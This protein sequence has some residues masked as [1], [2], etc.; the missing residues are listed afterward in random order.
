MLN[1]ARVRYH[2]LRP[3][4]AATLRLGIPIAIGQLGVIVMG[5]ADTMMVGHYSTDALAAASFVNNMFTFVSFLLM[6]YSYGLTPLISALVG[7]GKK[8]EAGTVLKNALAANV[9]YCALV[10]GIMTLLYFFLDRL[11]QP[12][13]LLPLIRPYYLIV[14]I[15]MAFVMLLNVFRQFTD[16][17]TDTATGMWALLSGNVLN[18]VGN[19]LLIYGIG[20]FPE[21]GLNGAGLSTLFARLVIVLI[22]LCVLL[23][24]RRYRE[25]R[26]GFFAGKTLSREVI[27]I[28]K[29]SLPVSLQMGMESGAFTFSAVMAGWMGAIELAAYQVLV[30][31]G[32]LGFLFYY[33]FGAG[34]SIRV[35]SF[36]GQ[37]D[38]ERVH[39][40]ALAGRDILLVIATFSSLVFFLFAAPM[41]KIFTTDAEVIAMGVTLIPALI[42]YQYGDAMQICYANVLRGTSHVLSMMWIAFVSYILINIPAAYLLAFTFGLGLH[43]IFIAFSIGLFTASALFYR[44]YR[45]VV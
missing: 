42:L 9:L 31:I 19:A 28:N 3:H 14:L 17:T 44:Q 18:I 43:G 32:T 1:N 4:Y 12:E 41:L 20:P 29:K 5:F 27:H 8:A 24:Y 11:G 33:S 38:R 36:I 40:S 15:S 23:R 37:S 45:R 34:T 13:H 26:I 30:T 25:Y 21:M 35:A 39:L 16:A 6:G 10:L 7:Q 22:F 2:R